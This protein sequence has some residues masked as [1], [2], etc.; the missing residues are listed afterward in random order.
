MNF[1]GAACMFFVQIVRRDM[2]ERRNKQL[3]YEAAL[4]EMEAERRREEEGRRQME[5]ERKRLAEVRRH[6]MAIEQSQAPREADAGGQ[7]GAPDEGDGGAAANGDGG[8]DGSG[9]NDWGGSGEHA[10]GEAAEGQGEK[11]GLDDSTGN[12]GEEDRTDDSSVPD[13]ANGEVLNRSG[14]PLCFWYMLRYR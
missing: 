13:A 11:N 1:N 2:E 3:A 6:R 5:I 10:D 4:R 14:H 9:G 8:G 7:W 12:A